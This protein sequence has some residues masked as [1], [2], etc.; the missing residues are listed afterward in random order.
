[1]DE[2]EERKRVAVR[3][4]MV[5]AKCPEYDVAVLYLEQAN[6]ELGDALERWTEDERWEREHPLQGGK[7]K[8]KA[9]GMRR[10]TGRG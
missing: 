9:V 2:E 10:F 7:G 8:G 6:G 4:F 1:M 5:Q 3:R